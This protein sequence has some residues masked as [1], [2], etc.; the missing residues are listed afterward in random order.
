MLQRFFAGCC[1]ELGRRWMMITWRQFKLCP[2]YI[3]KPPRPMLSLAILSV[4][5]SVSLV[6]AEAPHRV[7]LVVAHGDQV[8]KK[9]IEFAEDEITGYEVLERSGLDFNADVTNSLGAAI[10]RIDGQGCTYPAEDCFCQCQGTPCSFWSYWHLD[11]S[12]WRF[13][14]L[15]TSNYEVSDGDVEGWVWGEGTPNRGGSSPPAVTFE[16]I[17]AP[18]PSDTPTYTPEPP[19]A[20]PTPTFTPEPTDIPEPT[21]TPTSIPTPIIS[22]FTADRTSITAG[23]SVVLSWNLANAEAAYL[24]YNGVEEGVVAPGSK[25]VSPATTT[26]Y[27]LVARNDGGEA[28]TEV[29]IIVNP[30]AAASLAVNTA[31]VTPTIPIAAAPVAPA[32]ATPP[33]VQA[34]PVATVTPNLA[35][36]SPTPQ[37]VPSPE[38]SPTF[39]P[40][41]PSATLLAS[42]TST[43]LAV[44]PTPLAQLR[45]IRLQDHRS[46]PATAQANNRLERV[47]RLMA[48]VGIAAILVLFLATP[49]ALLGLGWLAWWLRRR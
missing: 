8:I 4:I 9:C 17:C 36:M 25:M 43:R 45:P 26:V 46:P 22:H 16:E 20:T 14:G 10:C 48:S 19:T 15:G 13:S 7:G 29:T 39:P 42:P 23:E 3:P 27:T 30:A 18:T 49:V 21:H 32:G 28:K 31:P 47:K 12:T 5:L 38:S 37:P 1:E 6:R 24:R 44:A 2:F 33:L 40:S 11:G 41:T 35:N 34:T